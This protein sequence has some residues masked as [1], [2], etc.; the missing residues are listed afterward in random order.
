[1][2]F[3]GDNPSG[4][5]AAVVVVVC[6]I[7]HGGR[8]RQNALHGYNGVGTRRKECGDASRRL[9]GF[10]ARQRERGGAPGRFGGFSA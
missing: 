4:G 8:D 1:M 6:A 9:D 2:R 5:E 7:S 10:G 3:G